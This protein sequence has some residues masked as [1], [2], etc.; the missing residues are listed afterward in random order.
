[1]DKDSLK[2]NMLLKKKN[3]RAD[4]KDNENCGIKESGNIQIYRVLAVKDEKVLVI[5]CV[6]KTMPVWM[7]IG[8]LDGFVEEEESNRSETG[9]ADMLEEYSTDV[10]KVIY[11]RY[12][13]ISEILPFVDNESM[14][15]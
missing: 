11:K 1:M 2:K 7:E 5:D 13:I 12:N 14:R 3:E 10:R 15:S 6:K 9:D 4:A 8:K